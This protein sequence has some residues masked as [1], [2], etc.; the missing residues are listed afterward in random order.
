MRF[1]PCLLFLEIYKNFNHYEIF[2]PLY[3]ILFIQPYRLPLSC[4]IIQF[5][6]SDSTTKGTA[7]K[8]GIFQPLL[9]LCH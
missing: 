8:D 5:A 2:L 6:I 4:Q 9:K 7:C 3:S 1:K